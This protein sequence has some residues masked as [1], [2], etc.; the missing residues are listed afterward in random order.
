M[1]KAMA[2]ELQNDGTICSGIKLCNPQ[3]LFYQSIPG[4]PKTLRAKNTGTLSVA[5]KTSCPGHILKTLFLLLHFQNPFEETPPA[6]RWQWHCGISLWYYGIALSAQLGLAS[7]KANRKPPQIH[8]GTL[9]FA[10]MFFLW[11]HCWQANIICLGLGVARWIAQPNQLNKRVWLQVLWGKRK[12]KY[13]VLNKSNHGHWKSSKCCKHQWKQVFVLLPDGH[14]VLQSFYAMTMEKWRIQKTPRSNIRMWPNACFSP[15]LGC[16]NLPAVVFLP[17]LA[18]RY[19]PLAAFNCLHLHPFMCCL[20]LPPTACYTS[21]PT[22]T[23]EGIWHL[24]FVD[25]I[26]LRGMAM[27]F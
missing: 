25:I 14:E 6:T 18:V 27:V 10:L 22:K 7:R 26:G 23:K 4:R 16:F 24:D 8:G 20:V 15:A 9:I 17:F 12:H 13:F 1:A 2:R 3:I 11:M 21:V 19:L 5:R